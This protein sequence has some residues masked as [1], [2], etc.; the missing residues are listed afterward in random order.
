VTFGFSCGYPPDVL[1]GNGA[2][3]EVRIYVALGRE[4]LRVVHGLAQVFDLPFE[5]AVPVQVVI[6]LLRN[7]QLH[8]SLHLRQPMFL[9]RKGV[10]YILHKR[11]ITHLPLH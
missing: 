9:R 5:P 11:H 2:R 1:Y 8:G 4:H 10:P 7:E 3:S 6:L